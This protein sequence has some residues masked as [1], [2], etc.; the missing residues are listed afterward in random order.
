MQFP[1]PAGPRDSPGRRQ[2]ALVSRSQARALEF[3][4]ATSVDPGG[5][6]LVRRLG[7]W[8]PG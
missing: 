8:V 7:K 2:G 5:G 4:A 1:F 3:S 6:V